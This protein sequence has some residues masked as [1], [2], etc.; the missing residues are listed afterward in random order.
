MTTPTPR[1]PDDLV[2]A[3][4]DAFD[5]VAPTTRA[6]A[7]EEL[8]EAGSTLPGSPRASPRLR[9]RNH[10]R[11]GPRS[12]PAPTK[13]GRPWYVLGYR[14]GAHSR[15][16]RRTRLR[17]VRTSTRIA[18]PLLDPP[19]GRTRRTAIAAPSAFERAGSGCRDFGGTEDAREAVALR[20]TLQ[21]R[22][23]CAQAARARISGSRSTKGRC[24]LPAMIAADCETETLRLSRNHSGPQSHCRPAVDALSST[25]SAANA[26]RYT[27]DPTRVSCERSALM[28]R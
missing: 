28:A 8:N 9:A 7:E 15:R 21:D 25:A 18:R 3:L 24:T 10:D 2:A 20:P 11:H 5:T 16:R 27:V 6:A 23:R 13:A 22:Q 17:R 1:R 19:H 4:A 14:R 12:L 26:G